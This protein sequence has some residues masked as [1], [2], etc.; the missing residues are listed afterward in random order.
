MLHLKPIFSALLRNRIAAGVIAVQIALTLA[1]VVNCAYLVVERVSDMARPSG[2]DEDNMLTIRV[3][4][5]DPTRTDIRAETQADLAV[6]RAMPGVVGAT[7]TNALPL[8]RGGWAWSLS[9]S[10]EK[11]GS[12]RDEDSEGAAIYM[13]DE[14][15]IDATGIELS[16]GRFFRAEEVVDLTQSGDASPSTIVISDALATALFGDEDPIGKPVW[17]NS[18]PG[19]APPIVVGTA[20]RLQAP[21]TSWQNTE[22]AAMVPYRFLYPHRTYLIRTEPGQREAVMGQVEKVLADRDSQRII[23]GLRS[24]AEIRERGYREQRAMAWI[25]TATMISLSLVT[26]LGIVGMASFWVT[27]RIKQI[28]TRRALGARR[29]DVR[30]Y[31]QVENGLISVGGILIG[32][33]LAWG[34]NVW[35]VSALALPKLPLAYLPIAALAVFVLGQLSVLGPARRASLVSPAVATRTV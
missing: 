9:N 5:M 35:L 13:V 33:A 26:A 34:L 10:L 17:L 25:L 12:G 1:I 11:A 31:F 29:F 15:G 30:R 24:Y 23:S 3:T 4:A 2:Y 27:Q 22:Q 21:W 19:R 16:R 14:M 20:K 32:M 8:G 28:G 7:A 6:L 18:E